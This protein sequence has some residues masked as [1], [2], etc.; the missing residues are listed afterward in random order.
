MIPI[1]IPT[2]N[3]I[4]S[5]L[6][7]MSLS[8]SDRNDCVATGRQ[9]VETCF[10]V[11]YITWWNCSFW[12]HHLCNSQPHHPQVPR[13]VGHQE[14]AREV[15]VKEPFWLRIFDAWVTKKV[16]HGDKSLVYLDSSRIEHYTVK[17]FF[18]RYQMLGP[19][20]N[21]RGERGKVG[22]C[23]DTVTYEVVQDGHMRLFTE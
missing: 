22:C 5:T 8:D 17:S 21:G 1:P 13:E 18:R 6:M 4:I 23:W 19:Q 11:L 9:R 20:E 10:L 7:C 12:C 2:K 16:G 14:R 3:G 15:P